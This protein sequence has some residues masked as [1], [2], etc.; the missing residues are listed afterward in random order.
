MNLGKVTKTKTS[1]VKDETGDLLA[2]SH[3][4]FNSWMKHICQ[5]LNVHGVDDV[6]YAYIYI[7]IYIYIYT[8]T[9]TQLID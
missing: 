9:H 5:L 8:H 7:Y 4:V 3:N 6:R 2:D 1:L